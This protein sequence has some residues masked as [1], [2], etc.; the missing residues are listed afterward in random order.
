MRPKSS[1]CIKIAALRAG[2]SLVEL[3]ASLVIIGLIVGAILSGVSMS[4][5]AEI[6]SVISDLQ[7]FREMYQ[8]FYNQ[9][10]QVPGDMA[11]AST[12]WP[13]ANVCSLGPTCNGDGDGII[14]AI[15]G[16]S[17][18]ETIRAWK[19]LELAGISGLGIA[20]IPA[21][22]TGVLLV[23]SMSPRS[24]IDG[25]GYYM[26]GGSDIGGDAG[27]TIIASPWTNRTNAV[28]LG[29]K[30]SSAT[31][32]GL[33]IGAVTGKIAYSID[34]KIDDGKLSGSSPIGQDTGKFR[35][36]NDSAGGT[37]CINGGSYILTST[38]KTCLVGYQL[39]DVNF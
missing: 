21:A 23:G 20:S 30:S 28:F 15:H 18:D 32:N 6:R 11:N 31:S 39:H 16:S 19:H 3:A 24:K 37:T 17:L 10:K 33:T 36:R 12:V 2:F 8:T 29:Q 35:T 34:I 22:Y 38:A 14:E 26:A 5:Q 1:V 7:S 25:A 4:S 9:Y 13:A 27:G